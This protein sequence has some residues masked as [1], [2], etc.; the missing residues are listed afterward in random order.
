MIILFIASFILLILSNY[1]GRFS[2]F[3]LYTTSFVFLGCFL[4]VIYHYFS[5]EDYIEHTGLYTDSYFGEYVI[6]CVVFCFAMIFGKISYSALPFKKKINNNYIS[7]GHSSQIFLVIAASMMLYLLN[8]HFAFFVTGVNPRIDLPLKLN[9]ILSFFI[10]FGLPLLSTLILCDNIYRINKY[11]LLVLMLLLAAGSISLASRGLFMIQAI[12]I[13]IPVAYFNKKNRFKYIIYFIILSIVV[14][15]A[16]YIYRQDLYIEGINYKEI[17]YEDL[18]KT[19]F[20]LFINRWI[21]AE[22][23]MV[24]ISEPSS[25]LDLFYSLMQESP[26][27]GN[28]ALYQI[29]SGR[30]YEDASGLS[31][32]TIPGFFGILSLS[33]SLVICFIGTYL[34]TIFGYIMEKYAGYCLKERVIPTSLATMYV[35]NSIMQ[36]NFPYLFLI[37][38]MN[39]V[40]F[41]ILIK[42]SRR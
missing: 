22:P 24:G 17:N 36:M 3:Y 13:L 37:L 1:K 30:P 5:Q 23:I 12:S 42:F 33:G 6:F 27:E 20:N 41:L 40:L 14:M 11:K 16:V 2:W 31:F 28:R 39:I 29:I 4:K 7:S 19:N 32:G 18:I 35:S 10:F 25:S 26:R 21:G 34:M 38:M 8:Y 9:V 15:Y